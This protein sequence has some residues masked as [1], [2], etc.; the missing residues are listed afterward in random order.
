[1]LDRVHLKDHYPLLLA[2]HAP[3]HAHIEISG[4]PEAAMVTMAG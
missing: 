3:R 2:M 1:M 4:V